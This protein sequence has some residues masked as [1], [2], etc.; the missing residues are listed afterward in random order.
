AELGHKRRR[1]R[2]S[3]VLQGS[4]SFALFVAKVGWSRTWETNFNAKAQ[5]RREAQGR[6]CGGTEG[7]TEIAEVAR[8]SRR[9][10]GGS[11]HS[12]SSFSLSCCGSGPGGVGW[13]R[14]EGGKRKRKGER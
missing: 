9:R 2:K 6:R 3:W 14:R 1:R 11:D 10:A 8:R 12:L 5:R 4:A 13:G 7:Y